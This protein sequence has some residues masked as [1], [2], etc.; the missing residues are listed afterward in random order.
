MT[1][2]GDLLMTFFEVARQ[3]SITMAARQLRVSQPTVTGRIRQL[4]ESYGVELFHRRASRVDLSD[5]GVALMPVVE[6][7]M[8]QEGNADYLLRNAGN[9][10]FGNLRIGATG[11]YYILR[12]VAAFRQRYPAI[13]VSLDIGN[14][15]QMLEALFEYRID[16]AVSS[17]PVDDDRLAR[18]RLA[19][20]PMVLVVHPDHAL[21]RLGQIDLPQLRGCHLLV[22]EHGSMTRKTTE[23]ALAACGLELP[24]HTVIGSR[25]AIYEA[26]RQ[27][28]GASVVP[29]GEVPR[30]PLL[31]V[32]PFASGAPVLH[33]YLY[34]LR[35]RRQT[36]LVGAFLDCVA[37]DQPAAAAQAA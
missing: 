15:Q 25:E 7:L 19:S 34:C 2:L 33:E 24:P 36:R 11:P 9:L 1:M 22:R 10:R 17:H 8:Q 29:L 16:A 13:D 4:E 18:V 37:L 30:D 6:Q 14:S 35:S 12:A 3:G 27:G 23:T 21:A 28:L 31:R 26:I 32:V 5:V 20:D